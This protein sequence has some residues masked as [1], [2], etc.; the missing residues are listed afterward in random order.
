MYGSGQGHRHSP[1]VASS[2]HESG[3]AFPAGHCGSFGSHSTVGSQNT[4]PEP[5]IAGATAEPA[6]TSTPATR[7]NILISPQDLLPP[8]TAPPTLRAYNNAV[9]LPLVSY[10]SAQRHR[11]ATGL[12]LICTTCIH[13]FV[14][15]D[16]YV[17][18]DES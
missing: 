5:R 12:Q 9:P 7:A 1:D 11:D 17:G 10:P 2:G 4:A 18:R 16:D 3:H 6:I 13:T 8:T 14:I 15:R